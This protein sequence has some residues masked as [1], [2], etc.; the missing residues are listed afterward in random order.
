[1]IQAWR[2]PVRQ[3]IKVLVFD[4]ERQGKAGPA[5]ASLRLETFAGKFVYH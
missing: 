5:V 1:M 4:S 3:E 2:E